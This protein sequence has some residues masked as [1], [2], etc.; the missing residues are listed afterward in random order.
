MAEFYGW[1]VLLHIIGLVVFAV[2][3]GVSMFVAFRVRAS[4]HQRAAVAA[5][6]DASSSSITPM[7]LGLLL[8][9]IGGLGAA[10]GGNLLTAP[11]VIASAVLLV[12]VVG[13]MYAIATPY[14]RSV[15]A[16]VSIQAPGAAPVGDPL[17]D[18]ELARMLDTRR[19]EI[20]LVVGGVG[21]VLLLW[22]MV[23]KP[24]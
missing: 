14:Y 9:I 3:H 13:L 19:P 4:R 12:V 22:L 21:L 17:T 10:A 16:A 18:D 7:Y 5:A 2:C 1:F 8:L 23:M 15:R 24:G 20:L 6:M 11:W